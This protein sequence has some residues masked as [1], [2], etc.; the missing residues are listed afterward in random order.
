MGI[1]CDH[2]LVAASGRAC[3]PVTSQPA[4]EAACGYEGHLLGLGLD[5]GD[6]MLPLL[7]A[8]GNQFRILVV[9]EPDDDLDCSQEWSVHNPDVGAVPFLTARRF[10]LGRTSRFS[11]AV[12]L[13]RRRG[14]TL[15]DLAILRPHLLAL[16][17]EP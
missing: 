5:A 14:G 10:V 15:Q 4:S 13:A 12:V 16:R 9:R 11:A 3:Q 17:V 2:R 7:E 6:E 1:Q 8:A